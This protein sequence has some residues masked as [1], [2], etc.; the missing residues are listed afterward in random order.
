[1]TKPDVGIPTQR[2]EKKMYRSKKLCFAMT[3]AAMLINPVAA[4]TIR[5]VATKKNTPVALTSMF[6]AKPDCT[7]GPIGIPVVKQSPAHGEVQLQIGVVDVPVI[8]ACPA[9][10][11]AVILLVYTPGTDFVGDDTIQLEVGLAGKVTDLRYQITVQN[12]K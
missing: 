1:M 11:T 10:K 9:R 5:S 2:D 6:Y 12:E 7:T 8:G 4:Q 3:F